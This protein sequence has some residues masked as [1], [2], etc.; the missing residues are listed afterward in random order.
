MTYSFLQSL[1]WENI[2]KKLGRKTWRVGG[3][4]IIEHCLPFG[5]KYLYAPRPDIADE[6]KFFYSAAEIAGKGG[7]VFL[8]IDPVSPVVFKNKIAAHSFQPRDTIICDLQKS[9][10]ELLAAM[11]EKTRYNIHLA[12]RKGVH[13]KNHESRIMNQGEAQEIF[14]NLLNETAKRDR[15][16]LHPPRYY[17][18]LLEIRSE[19]FSNEL[20]FAEYQNRPIA[21]ALIN[22]YRSETSIDGGTATYLHGASSS[23]QRN[24]MAPHLLHWEVMRRAK[25]M[26]FLQYDFWGVDEKRWPGVTRFKRGFGGKEMIYPDSFDIIYR[27]RY[28][29][30]YSLARAYRK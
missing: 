14:C 9:E 24:L 18:V 12:E 1:E 4:L 13:I 22:F 25:Q 5:F 17:K 15:F 16:H 27:K 19:C 20:F 8:K 21:A 7:H 2:Q 6:D 10:P 23:E 3:C 28:Y 30:L 29:T 11:H 26:G